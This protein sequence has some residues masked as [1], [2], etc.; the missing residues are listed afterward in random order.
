MWLT[1][2]GLVLAMNAVLVLVANPRWG[3]RVAFIPISITASF[4]SITVMCVKAIGY[5][6][7][8][9]AVFSDVICLQVVGRATLSVAAAA[10]W[11]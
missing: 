1:Y 4:G 9:N 10:G 8:L 2:V 5:E 3:T 11:Q 6:D 7:I